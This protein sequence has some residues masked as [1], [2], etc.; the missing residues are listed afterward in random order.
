VKALGGLDARL[1]ERF[2]NQNSAG[3]DSNRKSI[4]WEKA[5]QSGETIELAA[6]PGGVFIAGIICEIL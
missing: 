5:D 3:L 4:S 2:K 6:C 1:G